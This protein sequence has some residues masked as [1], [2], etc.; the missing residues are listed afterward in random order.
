MIAT[1]GDHPRQPRDQGHASS[2]LFGLVGLEGP[3]EKQFRQGLI[4]VPSSLCI[5]EGLS[6]N[7]TANLEIF[8]N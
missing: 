5:S 4:G 7:G 6:F 3:S 1:I 8:G 2:I